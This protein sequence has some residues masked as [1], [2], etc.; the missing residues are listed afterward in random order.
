MEFVIKDEI[1]SIL[2]AYHS[3]ISNVLPVLE[4]KLKSEGRIGFLDKTVDCEFYKYLSELNPEK[5]M[6]QGYIFRDILESKYEKAII[7]GLNTAKSAMPNMNYKSPEIVFLADIGTSAR[8]IGDNSFG[9][10]FTHL[11]HQIMKMPKPKEITMQELKKKGIEQALKSLESMVSHEA[12]HLY[13]DQIGYTKSENHF[14]ETLFGEGLATFIESEHYDA[15]YE[16]LKEKK[17]WQEII[18]GL[19]KDELT[20]FEIVDKIKKSDYIMSKES[21]KNLFINLESALNDPSSNFSK[22]LNNVLYNG[23][24]PIYHVGY[25]MWKDI[26]EKLGNEK[27]KELIKSGPDK[28]VETFEKIQ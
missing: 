1:S 17:L 26:S 23:N 18:L 7:K 12:S 27:V 6:I 28:F 9:I 3:D 4:K 10:N 11:Y 2:E 21:A 24:G 20:N 16:V 15:Y 5:R 22:N 8:I 19:I 25:V 14:K 13:L